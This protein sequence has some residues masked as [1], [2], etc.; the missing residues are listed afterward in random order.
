MKKHFLVF[1]S[2]AVLMM[3]CS[4]GQDV[5]PIKVI[6]LIPKT[7]SGETGQDSEPFLSIAKSNPA[8]MLVSA[9]T[10]NP[11]PSDE[12]TTPIFV[13]TNG[14][15]TW[16]LN[17]IVPSAKMTADITHA[18]VGDGQHAYAGILSHPDVAWEDP[19]VYKELDVVD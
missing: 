12:S 1:C 6:D 19:L 16:S 4:Y 2:C 13:T 14:G 9:F 10:M 7:L 11:D 18:I 17:S 15:E 3:A 5:D 8:K